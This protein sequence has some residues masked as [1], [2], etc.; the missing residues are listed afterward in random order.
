MSSDIFSA[1]D[2]VAAF[3]SNEIADTVPDHLRSEVRAAA[4]LLG[5]IAGEADALPALLQRECHAM[6]LLAEDATAALSEI[7]AD[8][9]SA[10]R[11]PDLR[12]RLDQ[13]LG[14]LRTLIGLHEEFKAD[15]ELILLRL[16]EL[17]AGPGLDDQA[18]QLL[19]GLQDRYFTM[20][21]DH[22]DARIPWQSVFPPLSAGES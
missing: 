17:L 20:L 4:K 9:Q 16:Q 12:H 13:P 11:L 22:A 7:A 1:L 3:L 6:L 10:T 14:S 15:A 8:I 5:D 21:A 2:A 18:A 19:A